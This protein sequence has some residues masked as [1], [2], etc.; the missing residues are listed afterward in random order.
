VKGGADATFETHTLDRRRTRRP[1]SRDHRGR[2]LLGR[3]RW[4]L[5]LL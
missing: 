5:R 1:G 4:R 3:R 2:S